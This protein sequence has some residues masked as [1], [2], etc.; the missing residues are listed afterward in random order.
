LIYNAALGHLK[1]GRAESAV[2]EFQRALRIEPKNPFFHKGI[3]VAYLALKRLPEAIAS[4]RK[5]LE[6]NPY[7]VD[8]RNDLGTALILSGAREEGKRELLAAYNEPMNP[9]PELT[10]RNLGRA[11]FDDGD[12]EQALTWF[13]T[14]VRRNPRYV[15]A[16]LGLADTLI[17]LNRVDEAIRHLESAVNTTSDRVDVVFA[18]GQAYYRAGRWDEARR[19]LEQVVQKDGASANG[20]K[21]ADLLKNLPK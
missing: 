19:R 3:G 10:S 2:E 16:H 6:L 20:R 5:A 13:R 4:F 11:Y 7:Y 9:T 14:S 21:A 17:G 1:E 8:A 18:L 15:D 12:L